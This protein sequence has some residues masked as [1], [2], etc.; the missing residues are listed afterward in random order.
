MN[1][2]RIEHG[3]TTVI[4]VAQDLAWCNFGLPSQPARAGRTGDW[5]LAMG[6]WPLASM[7]L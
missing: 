2:P 4:W 7:A 5:S 1:I 3:S 6:S